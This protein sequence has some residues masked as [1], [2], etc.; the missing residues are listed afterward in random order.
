M[1][2]LSTWARHNKWQ[3]RIVIIISWILLTLL[4]IYIG[5][6]L[7]ELNAISPVSV[8]ICSIGAFIVTFLIYP[9]KQQRET[10][11]IISFYT[12]Q[13]SCDII[14]AVSSFIMVFYVANKPQTLFSGYQFAHAF[15][16]NRTSLPTDSI[17]KS[18]KSTKDFSSSLKDGNGDRLKWKERKKMLKAQVK[19]IR[20]ADDLSKGE[21]TAL[22][23]LSV[24]VAIGLLALV[25]SAACSLSCNG[26]DG[27][28][29]L[30]GVGGTALVVWLLIFV[31]RR[32]NRKA[33][34]K[35]VKTEITNT[36]GQ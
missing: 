18:Y 2:R 27:A 16:I 36:P 13:K 8:F 24:L 12:W 21:K 19:A 22:I 1:K 35:R 7:K 26:A 20:E 9:L 14:V 29:V 32:I 5:I 28:A 6:T 25:A 17:H 15:V 33:K 34:K 31:V 11:K 23:V 4:G 3:A 10:K 30:V